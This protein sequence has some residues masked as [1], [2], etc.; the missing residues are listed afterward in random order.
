MT[1]VN[2]EKVSGRLLNWIIASSLHHKG[3]NH[4]RVRLDTDGGEHD[5]LIPNY[6]G[7]R[8]IG[9]A[10]T[11]LHGISSAKKHD[12]WWV[13]CRYNVNDDAT[14]MTIGRYR[15]VTELQCYLIH[16]VGRTF[17]VPDDIIKHFPESE[18]K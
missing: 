1:P 10:L 13:A 4:E 7:D 8:E 6:S 16:K 12:G 3:I 2:T 5:F 18:Y 11:E 9:Y 15:L 14:D 17:D